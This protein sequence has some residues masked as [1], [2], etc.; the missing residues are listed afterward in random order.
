MSDIMSSIILG[1]HKAS[2][3]CDPDDCLKPEQEPCSGMY[4]RRTVQRIVGFHDLGA[5]AGA[6]AAGT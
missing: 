3:H 4:A 2:K 1:I 5:G 6:A